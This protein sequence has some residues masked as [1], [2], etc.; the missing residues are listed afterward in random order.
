MAAMLSISF[1]HFFY[2][3]NYDII[4]AG[5]LIKSTKK[6]KRYLALFRF[7][8]QDNFK[9]HVENHISFENFR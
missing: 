9:K 3:F 4:P 6:K 8:F 1:C 7:C 5:F 2:L